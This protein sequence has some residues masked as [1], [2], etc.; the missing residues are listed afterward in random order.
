[1]LFAAVA[2]APFAICLTAV[3]LPRGASFRA[4]TFEVAG[5]EFERLTAG[6]NAVDGNAFPDEPP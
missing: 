3:A 2:P 6:F 1:M 4:C 5:I